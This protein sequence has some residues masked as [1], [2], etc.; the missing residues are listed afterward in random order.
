MRD[1]RNR[2]GGSDLLSNEK[3]HGNYMEM[4]IDSICIQIII[5]SASH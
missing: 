4:N 3:T 2:Y 1:R 5:A